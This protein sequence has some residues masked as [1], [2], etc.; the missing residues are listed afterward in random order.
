MLTAKKKK[1]AITSQMIGTTL[2]IPSQA[3]PMI[4]LKKDQAQMVRVNI[5]KS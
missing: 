4:T 5:I 2:K 1:R 3:I